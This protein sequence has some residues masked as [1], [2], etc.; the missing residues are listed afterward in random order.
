MGWPQKFAERENK[1]KLVCALWRLPCQ[2]LLQEKTPKTESRI[3]RTLSRQGQIEDLVSTNSFTKLLEFKISNLTNARLKVIRSIPLIHETLNFIIFKIIDHCN[4]IFDRIYVYLKHSDKSVTGE[5]PI[6]LFWP[7][8]KSY[9]YWP[10][11]Q[12]C[13][14]CLFPTSTWNHGWAS[15][16][17]TI[18]S[19]IKSRK[20]TKGSK[21]TEASRRIVKKLRYCECERNQLF[22][23]SMFEEEP[24]WSPVELLNSSSS[25]DL[26]P[27][28]L[29]A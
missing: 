5:T 10:V 26:P 27:E 23:L 11:S 12:P 20:Q 2:E 13:L 1:K 16:I 24:L 7:L 21:L 17:S 25:S 8:L 4:H 3:G 14:P 18:K 19:N 22:I 15:E 6:N 28:I 9:Q 29:A